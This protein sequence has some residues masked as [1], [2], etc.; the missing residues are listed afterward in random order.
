MLISLGDIRHRDDRTLLML[1]ALHDRAEAVSVLVDASAQLDLVDKQGDTALM[2]ATTQGHTDTVK[3]LLS[4]KAFLS[5]VNP[6]SD[7]ILK[8]AS[9]SSDLQ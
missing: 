6:P 5:A 8:S 4:A 9:P 3:C 7:S 2:L 1:A